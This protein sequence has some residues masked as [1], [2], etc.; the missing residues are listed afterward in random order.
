[1]FGNY[2]IFIANCCFSKVYVTKYGPKFNP[3]N[4]LNMG[5]IGLESLLE[6]F[7]FISFLGGR[8]QWEV[9]TYHP[10]MFPP[11]NFKPPPPPFQNPL[12]THGLKYRTEH[13]NPLKGP[14][15][16]IHSIVT[17]PGKIEGGRLE[18][19]CKWAWGSQNS[20]DCGTVVWYY[21]IIIMVACLL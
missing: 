12:Y 8:T 13:G 18:T 10:W 19:T 3:N 5:P 4:G 16:K 9:T 14:Q 21:Y 1:M 20:M 17:Q 11:L 2:Y 7:I 6:Y 15:N